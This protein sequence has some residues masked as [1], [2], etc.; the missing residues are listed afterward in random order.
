[1]VH[2]GANS[3]LPVS[4]NARFTLDT[5]NDGTIDSID[6]DDDGDGVSDAQEAVDG[7]NPLLSDTDSDGLSDSEEVTNGTNPLLS[8]TD[9]DGF[10]DEYEV[11]MGADPL[12]GDSIPRS[13]LNIL[14][15]KGALDI[16]KAKDLI[17]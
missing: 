15:I 1:M 11:S 7:T 3:P 9:G 5:D 2:T 6:T 13:G 10:S 17:N 14:L 12:D 16:K 4:I 8:D